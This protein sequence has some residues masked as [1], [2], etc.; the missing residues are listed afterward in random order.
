MEWLSEWRE[1]AESLLP[2]LTSSLAHF[3]TCS[4]LHRS[5]APRLAR[6]DGLVEVPVMV[7]GM[8]RLIVAVTAAPGFFPNKPPSKPPAV[9]PIALLT[10]PPSALLAVFIAAP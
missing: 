1:G 5:M 10:A 2:L 7:T 9:L 3:F 8:P 4:L 6:I